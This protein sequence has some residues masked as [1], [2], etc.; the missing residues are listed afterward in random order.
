MAGCGFSLRW[1]KALLTRAAFVP[2]LLPLLLGGCLESG[3]KAP[4]D[5]AE[6]RK[7][8]I[9]RDFLEAEKSFERY[10]RLSPEGEARWEVWNSLVDIAL[11]V[12]NDRKA[13]IELLEAMLIE[14]AEAPERKRAISVQLA[15]LY[16][17][18]RKYD[19]AV[20]LWS[21]VAEDQK[22][23]SLER[24]QACRNLAYVYLRRL[25]FELA[26]ESLGYCL[27]LDIPDGMRAECRYDLAQTF[28]GMEETDNAISELK[29]L[30]GLK[31]VPDA[32][33]TLAVFMLADALDQQGSNAEALDFFTSISETY[34]NRKVVEQR[35]EFLKKKKKTSP[36]TP[37]P[38]GNRR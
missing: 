37:P 11:S 30:L 10:L 20:L 9:S 35:V 26:K 13:A 14:Y 16:R 15:E 2:L 21:S 22:A 34:P 36:P 12:R 32:T 24:A 5:L 17:Q 29:T 8:M 19:R 25:E 1:L 33:R 27:A 23:D 28:M 7:A 6:A 38:P 18:L 3:E 4:D 31:H